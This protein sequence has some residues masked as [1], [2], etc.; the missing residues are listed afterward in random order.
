MLLCSAGHT[1]SFNTHL[2]TVS[3][4][5]KVLRDDVVSEK[6]TMAYDVVSE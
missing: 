4:P 3:G 2:T 1:L 6:K 5:D